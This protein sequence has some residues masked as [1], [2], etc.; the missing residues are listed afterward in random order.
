MLLRL[1]LVGDSYTVV[2]KTIFF[3][4]VGSARIGMQR[5]ARIIAMDKVRMFFIRLLV[6]A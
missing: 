3:A 5:V 4:L 6:K 1:G 2:D